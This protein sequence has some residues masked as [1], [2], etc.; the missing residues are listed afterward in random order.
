MRIR[1]IIFGQT[2]LLEVVVD[3]QNIHG[4]TA[5]SSGQ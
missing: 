1:R 2:T 5:P 4:E 3:H